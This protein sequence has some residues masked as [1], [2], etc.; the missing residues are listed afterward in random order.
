MLVCSA[1]MSDPHPGWPFDTSAEAQAF[2]DGVYRR[3]GGRERADIQ[4][5]L[6]RMARSI[7]EAGVRHR[8][9]DYDDGQVQR[10]VARLVLGDDLVRRVWPGGVLVD[11]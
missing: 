2:Q 11:P 9:P 7:A 6:S 4:F 10:A 5:R 1:R 8:H 3:L